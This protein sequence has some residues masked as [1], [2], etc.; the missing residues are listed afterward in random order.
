MTEDERL[1][2]ERMRQLEQRLAALERREYTSGGG[3]YAPA[4]KGVTNGDSHDHDGGDGAQIDHSKLKNLAADDHTQYH[5]DTRGDAR[6]AP[7]GKGVTNGDSHDHVGGDGAQIDHG[8]LAGLGDDDHSQYLK[9]DGSRTLS[10]NLTFT[11][12]LKSYKSSIAYD[13]YGIRLLTTM[14]TSTSWDGDAYSTTSKTKIDLSSVFGAP[15]G[16]KAVYVNVSIRD[17][18]AASGDYSLQL[19]P[20]NGAYTGI[21]FYCFPANDRWVNYTAIVPCDANG[22]IYYKIT[23][24]GAGTFDVYLQIYGYFL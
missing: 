16:I 11:G 22:D 20:D 7:I 15:D 6:Y 23:A 19:A 1:L 4:S 17:S 13:V 18:G 10:G 12:N 5:N 8:G 14:L 2:I 3:N 9:A 24:S 21:Y